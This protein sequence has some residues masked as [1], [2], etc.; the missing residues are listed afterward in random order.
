MLN[1]GSTLLAGPD[2]WPT[3]AY[4]YGFGSLFRKYTASGT[5]DDSFGLGGLI[6]HHEW[7]VTAMTAYRSG[8]LIGT[9]EVPGAAIRMWN[10]DG[11]V[12]STFGVGGRADLSAWL[13][14]IKEIH[15]LPGGKL[16]VVGVR[17][18]TWEEGTQHGIVR[19]L[20]SGQP[21]PSFGVGGYKPVVDGP[22][23]NQH[24]SWLSDSTVAPDGKLLIV[25]STGGSSSDVLAARFLPDGS[26]DSTFGFGGYSW[27]GSVAT[28]DY[29]GAI[30]MHGSSILVSATSLTGGAAHGFVT[31]LTDA[32]KVDISYGTKGTASA[33]VDSYAV[34]TAQLLPDGRNLLVGVSF[35]H[36]YGVLVMIAPDGTLDKAF[37]QQG[38]LVLPGATDITKV[39][40]TGPDQ[41]VVQGV[42]G[43]E[44]A[45]D[46]AQWKIDV[47]PTSTHTA[48][49][50]KAL[51]KYGVSMNAGTVT[52]AE[53]S[54]SNPSVVVTDYDRLVFS[55]YSVNLEVGATAG[56][57]SS[58]VSKTIVE[59]YTAFFDRVP[60]ADGLDFWFSQAHAGMAV[61]SIADAFY[62]AGV[63]HSALTGYSASM[64]NADFVN[65]VYRNVLGRSEG[66]DAEGLAFWTQ[67]LDSGV[68]SRGT[69]V[70]SILA[71]AHTFKGNAQFGWVADLLDNKYAVGKLF[72]VDMGLSFN[73]AEKSIT[74]GMRIADAVTPTSTAQAIALIGVNPADIELA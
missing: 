59:L 70:T 61:G 45:S 51:A 71:S 33:A 15:P 6:D 39:L 41:L 35:N 26:L 52:V 18:A 23:G 10:G 44:T 54:T 72:G 14:N 27:M 53:K 37:G 46:H 31:R 40:L 65:V 66:A 74:E 68:E 7:A 56:M 2:V 69:L 67:G 43:K 34:R 30:E 48:Q 63:A 13:R 1:D 57:L 20:A 16:L 47:S 64:G 9:A 60:D 5:I 12:D 32:G 55:D 17:V 19:L 49:F 3:G 29:P 24:I 11:T 25:G 62:Q 42:M 73:S 50:G 4:T 28:R 36:D 38:L 8:V 22:N 58:E 21:D